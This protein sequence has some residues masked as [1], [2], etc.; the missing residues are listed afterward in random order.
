MNSITSMKHI[1]ILHVPK[2]HFPSLLAASACCSSS[3]KETMN[4]TYQLVNA[5]ENDGRVVWKLQ[6]E[7]RNFAVPINFHVTT[8]I[9]S[10]CCLE[11]HGKPRVSSKL[12][13]PSHPKLG[14]C[15]EVVL[16]ASQ[17]GV[18]QTLAIHIQSLIFSKF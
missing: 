2:L 16:A 3:C 13:I 11:L 17:L 15:Q 4:E 12:C 6:Y 5:S 8:E 10:Y 18:L 14:C 9:I 1:R 7:T